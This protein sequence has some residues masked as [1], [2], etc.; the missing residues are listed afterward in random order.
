MPKC[1]VKRHSVTQPLDK[2]YRFIPL[3]QGRNA[4]VDAKDFGWLSEFN[5]QLVKKK[6]GKCYAT[7]SRNGS[8]KLL[9]HRLILGCKPKQE[10]DHKNSDGLD[11]RREN[12]RRCTR[13]QNA[14]NRQPNIG[15][16]SKKKGVSWHKHRNKWQS[17]I[18]ANGKRVYLGIF[19]TQEEAA[20]AY[21]KAAKDL[22]GAFAH[23][24][25][26]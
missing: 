14:K 8:P 20:R 19:N 22:H 17:E 12:L 2:P 18:Q 11:N 15:G 7:H 26:A 25:L 10:G 6:N 9:M 21:D 23:L 16:S 3:T 5:W 4:I 1:R 24:N 13:S